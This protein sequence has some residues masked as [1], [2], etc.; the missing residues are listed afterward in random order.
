VELISKNKISN[1]QKIAIL[2]VINRLIGQ[3][4]VEETA[5]RV[6][7]PYTLDSEGLRL[8]RA[9]KRIKSLV[10]YMIQDSVLSLRSHQRDEDVD[11]LN[12]LISHQFAETL[13]SGSAKVAELDSVTAFNYT[14]AALN[15]E[16]IAD[17]VSRIARI[18]MD[19]PSTFT[20]LNPD[21]EAFLGLETAL[22]DLIEES[23]S[24]LLLTDA[25]GPIR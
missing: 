19:L 11:H 5:S 1:D 3:E 6:V 16:R 10:K 17:H 8:E 23:V 9:L 14:Q 18:S 21:Q 2:Q 20:A 12:L 13:C 7:I 25:E 24:S 15:L 22:R 4:I